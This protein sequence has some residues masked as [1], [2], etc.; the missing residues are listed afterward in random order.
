MKI[1]H[2]CETFSETSETFIYDYVKGVEKL[3]ASSSVVCHHRMNEDSRPHNTVYQIKRPDRWHPA[4][5]L[6]RIRLRSSPEPFTV[7][8]WP[9]LRSQLRLVLQKDQPDVI[10]AH[11]GTVG[12]VMRPV[13]LALGI[14]LV[15]HFRG[16]D[17]SKILPSALWEAEYRKLFRDA[18][19]LVGISNHICEKIEALERTS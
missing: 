17:I 18:A 13:A 12:V 1:L 6:H 4:R 19:L 2:Y 11:F 3:G 16:Y 14:P 15:V 7:S 9:Q 8:F 5:V 10:H